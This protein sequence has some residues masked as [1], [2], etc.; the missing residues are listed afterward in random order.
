MPNNPMGQIADDSDR[1]EIV[2]PFS[3]FGK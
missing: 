1:L 2:R 3:L